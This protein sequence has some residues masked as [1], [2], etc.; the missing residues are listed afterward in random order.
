MNTLTGLEYAPTH[1]SSPAKDLMLI[2]VQLIAELDTSYMF[3]FICFHNLNSV[4]YLP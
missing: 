3:P 4:N 1:S 2:L